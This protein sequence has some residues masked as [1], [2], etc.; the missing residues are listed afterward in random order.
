MIP[1]NAQK[2]AGFFHALLRVWNIARNSGATM[3]FYAPER[4][5]EILKRISKKATIEAEFIATKSWKDGETIASQ[6]RQDEAIII[7]MAKRGMKSYIPQMRL[8]PEL[9]NKYVNDKNYLL[10]FPFSESDNSN[11]E[12]RSVG[13]H[14]DF[15]EIG[16]VIKKIFG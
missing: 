6:L 5:L 4:I 14:D 12:K 13:N 16:N 9:L 10:V 2:E 7:M 8:I 1:E 3:T 15:M 11:L